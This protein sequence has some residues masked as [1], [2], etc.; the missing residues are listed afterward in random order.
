MVG[1]RGIEPPTSPSRTVRA[2]PALH[3]V[4]EVYAPISFWLK[5]KSF[6]LVRDFSSQNSKQPQAAW[7]EILCK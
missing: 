1:V 5:A 6:D 4:V 2:T 3:P 7:F